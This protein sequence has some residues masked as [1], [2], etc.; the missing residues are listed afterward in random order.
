MKF[1]IVTDLHYSDIEISGKNRHHSKSLNKLKNAV[2]EYSDGCN[3]IAC[4]GDIADAFPQK[5]PQAVGI[6]QLKEVW[7]SAGIPFYATFGNHDTAMD[8]KEFMALTEMPDRYYSFE[9]DD[10]LFLMLDTCMNS[11]D[12]PYPKKEIKWA[13]CYIDDQQLNWMKNKIEAS[14]KKIVIFTHIMLSNGGTDEVD[15][16]L[17]NS[18]EVTDILLQN[19]EKIAAVFCGHNHF[20]LISFIGKIPFITLKSMCIGE[21]NTFAVVELTNNRLMINGYGNEANMCFKIN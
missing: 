14:S 13:D 17:N 3:F 19:E 7:K 20:G 4:L 12:E 2:T 6:A 8:K 11:K 21:E 5:L 15:H 16:V 18:N 10:F 1:L 9:S